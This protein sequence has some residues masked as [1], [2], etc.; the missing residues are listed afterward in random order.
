MTRLPPLLAALLLPAHALAAVA[1]SQVEVLN[2]WWAKD[3]SIRHLVVHFQPT[4]ASGG[5]ST[6]TLRHGGTDLVDIRVKETVGTGATEYPVSV[7][8]PLPAGQYFDTAG[9]SVA[10]APAPAEPV[11]VVD[12]AGLITVTT[13]P[14]RFTVNKNDFNVLDTV[15]FDDDGNRVYADAERVVLPDDGVTRFHGA[16]VEGCDET[17]SAASCTDG[18]GAARRTQRDRSMNAPTVTV[19]ESGPLRAV[20]RAWLPTEYRDADD[21]GTAERHDHGYAVRIYAYAGKS[22]VKVDYQLQNAALGSDLTGGKWA[23][24]FYFDSV[25]LEWNLELG[26]PTLRIGRHDGSVYSQALGSGALLAQES[27]DVYAIRDAASG[28]AKP[29]ETCS[30][31]ADTCQPYGWIDVT[32]GRRGVLATIRNFWQMWPNGLEVDGGGRLSLQLW[33]DWSSMWVEDQSRFTSS[34]LYW[35]ED[36]QAAFKETLLWFHGAG[37]TDAERNRLAKTFQYHPVPVLPV[38]WYEETAVT[39]DLDGHHALTRPVGA[40]QRLPSYTAADMNRNDANYRMGWDNFYIL[41][42]RKNAPDQAGDWVPSMEYF[43]ASESPHHYWEA[44]AYAFGEMNIRPQWMPGYDYEDHFG[45]LGLDPGEGSYRAGND[46]AD[47]AIADTARDAKGWGD[48]HAWTQPVEEVYYYTGNPWLRDHYAFFGEF[49]K[50]RLN[51]TDGYSNP[52]TR[53]AGH[54]LSQV[55]QSFRIHG[56]TDLLAQLTQHMQDRIRREQNPRCGQRT[57]TVPGYVPDLGPDTEGVFE[58]GYFLRM[59]I[60]Y[61]AELPRESQAWAD[62]F[63][64]VSGM[65]VWNDVTANWKYRLHR[66]SPAPCGE[67]GTA[68]GYQSHTMPDPVAWYYWQT[69]LQSYKDDVVT[70]VEQGV[71]PGVGQQPGGGSWSGWDGGY[72][73]RYYDWVMRG[74]ARPDTVPPGSPTNVS[75]FLAGTTATVTWS[76][77]PDA[78]RHHVVW[79]DKPISA[80]Y[81][82]DPGVTNWWAGRAVDPSTITSDGSTNQVAFQVD[83]DPVFVAVFAWDDALNLSAMTAASSDGSVEDDT[84]PTVPGGVTAAGVSDSAIEVDWTPSADPDS[85]VNRYKVYRDGLLVAQPALPP[86]LDEGLAEATSH[87]Y[88]VSAVNGAG[89]ES[90][91]SAPASGTTLADTTRPV[92][93]SA[94]AAGDPQRVLVAFSE[95]LQQASAENPAN[96]AVDNGVTVA[97]AVLQDDLAT[98]LLNTSPHSDGV[99]YTL[100]VNNV[101]DRAATPNTIAANSQTTYELLTALVISNI[102][103]ASGRAY[104]DVE[105]LADGATAYIDRGFGYSGVPGHLVGSTYIMT[106]NDDKESQG[107]GFLEFDVNQAVTVYV[108]H[109]DRYAT[110]PGWLGSFA[111]SGEDLTIDVVFSLYKR[112]FA[113][114]RI[115][116][117]GNVDPAEPEANSMYTVIVVPAEIPVPEFPPDAPTRLRIKV[118]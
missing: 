70:Y 105:G 40:E 51:N 48:E 118:E 66:W 18:G 10:G 36:M 52:S 72:Q 16:R 89:L 106:A 24:P 34:G 22:F 113:R 8:V 7:V 30:S 23:D 87:S 98:V 53:A 92:L 97:G 2:R 79:S 69:G 103:V 33:P 3:D 13:G 54:V 1:S 101:K 17:R 115:S 107:D 27:D 88:R 63:N 74:A 21:N 104:T 41:P 110:K 46:T 94:L 14:L 73:A 19:E 28:A 77:D 80:G 32:D 12:G 56:D 64:L 109:D 90:G 95:P 102:A 59:M 75:V 76:A 47:Y 43:V 85:G 116:L 57:L 20:I 6:Y 99:V 81:S 25:D 58:V 68:S 71:P 9:F 83:A 117:G 112:E 49:R 78:A 45:Q 26:S 60:E 11:T 31:P 108:A 84:P 86:Y 93:L 38:T 65:V 29:G 62:A 50:G 82:S 44:E 55:M 100:T 114:G 39:L 61:M 91:Q 4:V 37:T 67:S 5:T 111:D 15:W 96:Y 42:N 35:L